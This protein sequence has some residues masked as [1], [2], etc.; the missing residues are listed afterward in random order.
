MKHLAILMCCLL[1]LSACRHSPHPALARADS[2][3]AGSPDSALAIIDS[4]NPVTLTAA[5]RHL[6]DLLYIKARDKA[7]ITHTSDSL[8]LDVIDWYQSH[9]SR[10]LPE[11]LYYGA[12][13]YSDLGDFPTALRYFHDAADALPADADS[14]LRRNLLS[15]TGALLIRLRLFHQALEYLEKS[16]RLSKEMDDPEICFDYQQLGSTYMHMHD[17]K[18]AERYFTNAYK[19]SKKCPQYITASMQTYLAAVKYKQHDY[20]AA[21]ALI[22][23][24]PENID[25]I[26]KDFIISYAADIYYAADY[27]DSAYV[28]ALRNLHSRDHSYRRD[29]YRML[30][31]PKLRPRIH[32]DTI[33]NYFERYLQALE[34]NY[35]DHD[36]QAAIVQNSLYNYSFHERKAAALSN[37]RVK[38]LTLSVILLCVI[39]TLIVVSAYLAHQN[40]LRRER[41]RDALTELQTLNHRLNPDVAPSHPATNQSSRQLQG[42]IYEQI[43]R[44]KQ[45]VLTA[46][47]PPEDIPDTE[48][49]QAITDALQKGTIL[50]PDN[51]V[52]NT[53][54]H[55]VAR[56][57]PRFEETL[58]I[59]SDGHLSPQDY[60][61]AML[62][63]LGIQS[64]DIAT[65]FGRVKGTITYRRQLL[66]KKCFHGQIVPA[67]LDRIIRSI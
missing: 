62:I 40:R 17:Y 43:D 2:L 25:S 45:G 44:L 59:L 47:P 67:E 48:G 4:L 27:L 1:A 26:D 36:A 6:R 8:I 50:L 13:V 10:R 29:A 64:K 33:T 41:L 61:L 53:I 42:H 12:R 11:A 63:R 37:T 55:T 60:Q 23:T 14:S 35:N 9:D 34:A 22:Q 52:W 16:L 66:C 32:P 5:D 65:L 54:N 38:L 18:T 51:P 7:Y 21:L 39:L 15:Q 57:S 46:P 28:Y 19:H 58:K 20:D 56:L 30:L 24:L 49:Y 3:A 31:S